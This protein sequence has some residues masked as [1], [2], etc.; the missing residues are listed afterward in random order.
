MI[1][2]RR[3]LALAAALAACGRSSTP[4][5]PPPVRVQPSDVLTVGSATLETGPEV[6][7]TLEAAQVA[8]V[9][10]KIGGTVLAVGPE[11]GQ[12]VARGT[13]L[14]RIDPGALRQTVA[15]ARSALS[16]AEQQ[17]ADA[18]ADVS[19]DQA[20]LQ[21]GAIP[22]HDLEVAQTRVQTQE[23]AI[24]Q[25]RSALATAQHQLADATV[26]SPIAGVVS[27]RAVS[28]GDV[29]APGTA[30]YTIIDPSSIRL[31]AS[32]P[33]EQV[34]AVHVGQAVHFEVRG[35]PGQTFTGT[36]TRI[37][38]S[39]EPNTRQIAVLIEMANPGEKLLAGLF[40][41][42]YVVAQS[43]T[44]P[45]IPA[46]ALDLTTGSPAVM[47]IAGGVVQRVPVELGIRDL[48][49][50]RVI[51]T[52]GIAPGAVVFARANAAPPAGTTVILPAPAPSR[53]PAS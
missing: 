30:L 9:R 18:R 41:H 15:S 7:G 35:Y 52:R 21:A 8:Q 44:G 39:A 43:Q 4:P 5:P 42:G 3:V 29:V 47:A 37:A 28:A 11:L 20:L 6:S 14:A 16:A 34:S 53:F 26:R 40:A 36:V 13:L 51:V 27:A 46:T 12:H 50:D 23:A 22:R 32:V 45:V 1:A 25:A 24:E 48:M 33:S 38:P 10:A 17:L 31:S 49:T 19:R 2:G